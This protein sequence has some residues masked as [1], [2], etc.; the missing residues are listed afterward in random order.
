MLE[1]PL[2]AHLCPT[3]A[4]RRRDAP[5]AAR[6]P[7]PLGTAGNIIDLPPSTD[8]W[9]D[10]VRFTAERALHLV[11][12]GRREC[13]RRSP[14]PDRPGAAAAGSIAGSR[15]LSQIG[16]Y[17]RD[18]P[19]RHQR[20]WT[21]PTGPGGGR[22][23]EGRRTGHRRCPGRRQAR[24]VLGRLIVGGQRARGCTGRPRPSIGSR[25]RPTAGRRS[26]EEGAV[27]PTAAGAMGSR[28]G[29][30][31]LSMEVSRFQACCESRFFHCG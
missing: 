18:P 23:A 1:E 26:S 13:P 11:A 22:S 4:R 24:R 15:S 2:F 30:I 5:R 7:T 16:R 8:F 3:P 19:R 6:T 31:L 21:P 25:G 9:P 29:S 14:P 28:I 27:A 17:I 10:D 20:P 12:S